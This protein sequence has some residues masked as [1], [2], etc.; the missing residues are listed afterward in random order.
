MVEKELNELKGTL[1]MNG[2]PSHIIK[3]GIS[4]EVI[5]RKQSKTETKEVKKETIY[6]MTTHYGQESLVFA[7]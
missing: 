1:Q 7:S 6:L 2:Y 4:E 3:R 5:Y